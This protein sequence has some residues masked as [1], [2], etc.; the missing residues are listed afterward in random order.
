MKSSIKIRSLLLLIA[1]SIGTSSAF[2][3]QKDSSSLPGEKLG[4]ESLY[5]G[6]QLSELLKL[7][8]D[9]PDD[10]ALKAEL[11]RQYW[12][13]GKRG[14]AV[15]HWKWL[16]NRSTHSLGEWDWKEM[17]SL[18]SSDQTS[19]RI[20]SLLVCSSLKKPLSARATGLSSYLK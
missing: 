7:E 17:L 19:L 16:E 1:L 5:T 20:R 11:A 8:Y 4:A 15:E 3:N 13:Q 14:L 12:C 2:A 6:T 9:R 18:V 10:P